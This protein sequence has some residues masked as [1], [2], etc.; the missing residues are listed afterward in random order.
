MFYYSLKGIKRRF[1]RSHVIKMRAQ[2]FARGY[3]KHIQPAK[4]LYTFSQSV[5]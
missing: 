2:T 5:S 1:N 3:K 4:A